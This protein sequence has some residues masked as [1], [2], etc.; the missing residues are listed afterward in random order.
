M[1]YCI[2]NQEKQIP[3]DYTMTK[4][5]REKHTQNIKDVLLSKKWDKDR[6]G[7]FKK[8]IKRGG[9]EELFRCKFQATSMRFE[10]KTNSGWFNLTSD[11]Y[12]NIKVIDN[13]IHVKRYVL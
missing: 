10:V 7:N 3:K 6:W 11:Y 8:I 13:K 5:Q 1:L 9:K 12:K 4:K 2:H